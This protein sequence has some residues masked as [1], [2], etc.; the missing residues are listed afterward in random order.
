MKNNFVMQSSAEKGMRMAH[1]R[2]VSGI[3]RARIE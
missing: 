3:L 1:H 2:S